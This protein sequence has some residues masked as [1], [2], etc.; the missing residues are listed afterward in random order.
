MNSSWE[1][2]APDLQ[3]RRSHLPK[4]DWIQICFQPGEAAAKLFQELELPSEVVGHLV[5]QDYLPEVSRSEDELLLHWT[6]VS[7]QP[8]VE[9]EI[10]F[11]HYSPDRLVTIHPL[12]SAIAKHW[13]ESW[14]PKMTN[15]LEC[16]AALIYLMADDLLDNHFCMLDTL[17]DDV[18][19]LEDDMLNEKPRS[20]LEILQARRR[21]TEIR[22][23]T[24]PLRDSLNR[25]LRPDIESISAN[26][27]R[28]LHEGYD[29]S[30]R[31]MERTDL[32]RDVVS[33]LLD[34][35]H[36]QRANELN[37][38]MMTLTVVST[39][40]MTV[41][42]FTGWYGMNFHFMPELSHRASYPALMGFVAV[43]I[44]LE[45]WLFRRK[46]WI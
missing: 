12:G 1:P 14:G 18:D 28:L 38:V 37:K 6:I 8:G 31:V 35:H 10:M 26:V 13:S 23:A 45:L 17:E 34:T 2:V 15:F 27:R 3:V 29:Q 19:L 39:C 24:A 30:L 40:L 42:L 41:G 7:N 32:C 5:G 4:W 9:P 25:L 36:T 11:L 33:D 43:V 44:L 20:L 16:P 21:V 22:R 46:R